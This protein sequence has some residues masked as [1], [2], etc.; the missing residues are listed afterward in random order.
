MTPPFGFR[1][2]FTPPFFIQINLT[3]R[4]R[5]HIIVHDQPTHNYFTHAS[6][7]FREDKKIHIEH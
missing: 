5:N 2:K 4:T 1:E 3:F 6:G 7:T